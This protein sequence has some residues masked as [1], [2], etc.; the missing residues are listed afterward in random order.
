MTTCT[1]SACPASSSSGSSSG[2]DEVTY[3]DGYTESKRNAHIATVVIFFVFGVVLIVI[4]WVYR[5]N[6]EV[7][8]RTLVASGGVLAVI[9]LLALVPIV[10]Q[11][12]VDGRTVRVAA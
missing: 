12:V 4:G 10:R 9:M 2:S 8:Y 5:T 7:L 11:P 1:T 6:P 3:T